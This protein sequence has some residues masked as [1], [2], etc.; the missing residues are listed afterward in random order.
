MSWVPHTKITFSGIFGDAEAPYEQWAFGL[1]IA[2]DDGS[3]IKLDP[4]GPSDAAGYCT[5]F[6][7]AVSSTAVKLTQTKMANVDT[8]GHYTGAPV[9][10]V[11]TPAGGAGQLA[12]PSQIALVI[13]LWD[14]PTHFPR[15]HGRFYIPGPKGGL[16]PATGLVSAQTVSDAQSAAVAL[17]SGLNSDFDPD[18]PGGHVII[19]SQKGIGQNA[20]VKQIRTGFVYDTMR[21]RRRSLKEAYVSAPIT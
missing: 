7:S 19:A 1:S 18:G 9:I 20:R 17:I 5:T 21:S 6:L 10:H 8:L 12:M 14:D 2:H 11:S 15:T 13:S 16:D 4:T 3:T